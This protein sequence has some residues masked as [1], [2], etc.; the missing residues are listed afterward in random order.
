MKAPPEEISK[1]LR[2]W[3]G[4]SV[5]DKILEIKPAHTDDADVIVSAPTGVTVNFSFSAL[6]PNTSTMQSA[7]EASLVA[8]FRDETS[9]GQDL[10]E[11]AYFSA[12]QNTVDPETGVGV[13]SFT[14]STP[15]GDVA[16]AAGELPI[17]GTVS[18]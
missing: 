5:K 13:T 17:L 6:V 18:F 11:A 1:I 15:T 8:Y 4:A 9:V 3:V 12:I 10:T 7:I 16:I 2:S 14:L